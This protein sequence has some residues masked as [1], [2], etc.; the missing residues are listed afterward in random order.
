MT[1]LCHKKRK[2]TTL[3][4]MLYLGCASILFGVLGNMLGTA[5]ENNEMLYGMITG[6]GF[7]ILL[8]GAFMLVRNKLVAPEKLNEEKIAQEDE[9]NIT[10]NRAA[11]LVGYYTAIGLLAV[12]AFLFVGLGYRVPSFVCVG[13]MYV[14]FIAFIIAQKVLAAKM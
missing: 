4:L 1:M 2:R 7:G 9:R 5:G 3:V 14:L 13:G 12:L 8:V 11:G 10:I 6:F